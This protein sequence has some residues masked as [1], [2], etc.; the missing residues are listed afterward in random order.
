MDKETKYM[1][2]TL[3]DFPIG[4]KIYYFYMPVIQGVVMGDVLTDK[5]KKQYR[6]IDGRTQLSLENIDLEKYKLFEFITPDF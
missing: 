5:N 1:A 3:E 6:I 4:K 2:L